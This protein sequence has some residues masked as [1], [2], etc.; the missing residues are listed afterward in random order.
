MGED[1]RIKKLER[2][3]VHF[4]SPYLPDRV[5]IFGGMSFKVSPYKSKPLQCAKCCHMGHFI[6]EC[7]RKTL[8]C[9]YCTGGH[10]IADCPV[11]PQED[12]SPTCILCSNGHMAT[13]KDCPVY[14]DQVQR[15]RNSPFPNLHNRKSLFVPRA[16]NNLPLNE[17]NYPNISTQN[18]YENLTLIEEEISEHDS[19]CSPYTP[20]SPTRTRQQ[21]ASENVTQ[22]I[23]TGFSTTRRPSYATTFA[24]GS[25]TS[26]HSPA[27]YAA[28][29]SIRDRDNPNFGHNTNIVSLLIARQERLIEQLMNRQDRLMEERF[30][31][32]NS[33]ITEL[34]T[35]TLAS[36]LPDIITQIHQALTNPSNPTTE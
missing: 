29:M 28:E 21:P 2:V 12:S 7:R 8:Q 16:P 19:P 32:H 34:V 15:I 11:Q 30:K 26:Y 23:N 6:N 1:G 20:R 9:A 36:L 27:T 24:T 25:L 14:A 31:Q 17:N 3:A 5:H 13:S 33:Q 10:I 35:Q 4:T 22:S 18:R